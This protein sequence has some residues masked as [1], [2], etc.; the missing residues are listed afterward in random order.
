MTGR[1]T[2]YYLD[3]LKRVRKGKPPVDD[4]G[5]Y[6]ELLAFGPDQTYRTTSLGMALNNRLA[7]LFFD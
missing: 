2:E 3:I 4:E 5:L 1:D 7:Q 6:L